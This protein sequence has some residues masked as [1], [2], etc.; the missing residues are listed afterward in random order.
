MSDNL[1]AQPGG[2]FLALP[3]E[4]RLLIYEMLFPPCKVCL[5]GAASDFPWGREDQDQHPALLST[6]RTI[7]AEA[8]SVLY[9]NIEFRVGCGPGPDFGPGDDEDALSEDALSED[10]SSENSLSE[11]ALMEGSRSEG[12]PSEDIQLPGDILDAKSLVDK[13]RKLF[14]TV[15]LTNASAWAYLEDRATWFK[16]LASELTFLTEAPHLKQVHIELEAPEGPG[17]AADFDETISL[18]SQ[19]MSHLSL[20]ISI[21]PSLRAADFEP[22][23]YFDMLA[24]LNW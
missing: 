24:K 14:L 17:I 21:Q 23:V 16:N 3:S 6:C 19:I 10:S 15:T 22:S 9:E 13:M 4:V 20:T 2:P 11:N 8:K 7:Y 12:S 5:Y 1:E 18:L